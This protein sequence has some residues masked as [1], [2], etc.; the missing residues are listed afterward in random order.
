MEP[1]EKTRST[2]LV[3]FSSETYN[4]PTIILIVLLSQE[5]KI[6]LFLKISYTQMVQ[7]QN[8]QVNSG[9]ANL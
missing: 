9:D 3:F 5:A 7:L 1:K 8:L 4:E 6:W 2:A